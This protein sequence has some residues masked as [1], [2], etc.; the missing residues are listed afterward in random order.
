MRRKLEGPQITSSHQIP[1]A[2][3]VR[4]NHLRARRAAVLV[5]HLLPHRGHQQLVDALLQLAHKEQRD[6]YVYVSDDV[7]AR[8]VLSAEAALQTWVDLYPQHRELFRLVP[9][10]GDIGRKIS[11]EL[12]RHYD[13]AAQTFAP[14]HDIVFLT[15]EGEPKNF[16]MWLES[17]QRR[18]N[19][20]GAGISRG[21]RLSLRTRQEFV[22]EPPVIRTSDLVALATHRDLPTEERSARWRAAFDPRLND[23]WVFGLLETALRIAA[24]VA[25]DQPASRRTEQAFGI[26]GEP[27][28]TDQIWKKAAD[29]YLLRKTGQ[30]WRLVDEHGVTVRRLVV[31]DRYV[32]MWLE[33]D[34]YWW[35][36]LDTRAL[37]NG[38]WFRWFDRSR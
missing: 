17:A 36:E 16:R 31:P 20:D 29:R 37:L 12:Q 25:E 28:K 1:W 15:G 30:T 27:S 22:V 23:D 8:D 32:A 24:G 6:P 9:A 4:R 33:E 18:L 11:L 21:A 14:Y 7:R 34:G 3:R 38:E 35:S 26:D 5:G 2:F 10:E 13:E 19:A